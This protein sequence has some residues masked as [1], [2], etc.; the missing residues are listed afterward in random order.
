MSLSRQRLV[1][2]W[3]Q[4]PWILPRRIESSAADWIRRAARRSGWYAGLR[5]NWHEPMYA[6]GVTVNPP[7]SDLPEAARAEFQHVASRR[8]PAAGVFHLTGASLVGD[9]G[10]VVTPDNHLLA[11]FH[12]RFTGSPR[13]RKLDLLDLAPRRFGAPVALLAAP[14]ARN[15][16]HWLF[17]VLPRLHLL[18]RWRDVI[19]HYA[20]PAGLNAVQRESLQLLGIKPEQLLELPSRGRLRCQHLYVASLPGSEGCYAPWA[21]EFL[22]TIFL[23]AAASTVGAGP[24]IYIHRGPQAKR[25]VLN[26]D[27]LTDRLERRGFRIVQLEK[28]SLVEQVA[29]F[30]DARVLVAAHGAGLANLAFARRTALLELFSQDY[31]RPDCYFTLCRQAG[32]PYDCWLDPHGPGTATP[33]GA[34]TVDLAAVEKKLD[35]LERMIAPA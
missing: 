1:D 30:R 32:H 35:A 31:L 29:I 21:R 14:E 27:A 13:P 33:W 25:P 3:R 4:W 5:G 19:E 26:E 9:Q 16:Y 22:R 8:H 28:H 6:E 23:P 12:H 34:I 7:P 24:R 2:I 11:E 15:H 17:D 10:M 18:E 20:V